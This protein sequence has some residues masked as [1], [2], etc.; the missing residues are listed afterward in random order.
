MKSKIEEVFKYLFE[1]FREHPEGILKYSLEI[2]KIF[3]MLMKWICNLLLN[4]KK[5]VF[6]IFLGSFFPS[7]NKDYIF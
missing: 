1:A 3:A 7:N 2:L 5:S 4:L 6:N